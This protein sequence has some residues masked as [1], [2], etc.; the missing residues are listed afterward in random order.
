L[1][2]KEVD[3]DGVPVSAEDIRLWLDAVDLAD[4]D[5]NA[6]YCDIFV[7]DKV[8]EGWLYDEFNSDAKPPSIAVGIDL[9]WQKTPARRFIWKLMESCKIFSREEI[10]TR[11]T[12]IAAKSK[13]LTTNATLVTAAQ[14]F[15][16]KL[17]QLEKEGSK[18]HDD[19]VEF[20]C[21]FYEEWAKHYPEFLPGATY[22]ARWALRDRSFALSNIM[23]FPMFRMA[24]ELWEGYRAQGKDWRTEQGWKD[25][26]AKIAGKT[27]EKDEDG[28]DLVVNVMD[29]DNPAWHGKVLI[30]KFDQ[31]GN[32][33]GWSLSSTRQTRDAA[34]HYLMAVAGLN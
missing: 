24:F 26:L 8:K 14:P 10:Q 33:K 28:N 1:V 22:D 3:V 30:R 13:K 12:T 7:L 17:A 4:P 31:D 23:F 29:R 16:R 21:S 19:L 18:A 34:Y 5:T 20:V 27:T 9:N 11:S 15:R 2:P 6:V 25:A 32:P